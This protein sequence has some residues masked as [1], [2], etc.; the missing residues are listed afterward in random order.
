MTLSADSTRIHRWN[1][2]L[3]FGSKLLAKPARGGKNHNLGNLINKRSAVY[4][5]PAHSVQSN[6]RTGYVQPRRNGESRENILA[7]AV[8]S[9]IE[10]G[11]LRA[12]IRLI[13]SDDAVAPH[14]AETLAALESKHPKAP[15]DRELP[16]RPND[17]VAFQ[18]TCDDVRDAIR[19]VPSGLFW[20]P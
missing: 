7:A 13:C 8:T 4:N 15:P 16:A 1:D 3:M 17:T 12:A 19:S 18:V 6:N 2:L 5:D 9:K 20:W 14:N 10:D 11:N